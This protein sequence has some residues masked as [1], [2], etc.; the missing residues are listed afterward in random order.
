MTYLNGN[1]RFS[2]SISIITRFNKSRLCLK[3]Y[4]KLTLKAGNNL[5]NLW[6][7]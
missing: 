6:L 7:G 1:K 3:E 4:L 5:F 2:K